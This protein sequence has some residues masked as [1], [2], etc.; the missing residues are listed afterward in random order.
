MTDFSLQNIKE[1]A[2][3][4]IWDQ[5]S[6]QEFFDRVYAVTGLPMICFD[7]SFHHIAHAFELP[8]YL[9][10][11]VE[12]S[13]NRS[14]SHEEIDRYNYLAYQEKVVSANKSI[15]VMP[16]RD[17]G[18]PCV[19]C[20]VTYQGE[21]L[22][23]CGTVLEDC[24]QNLAL[25]LNDLVSQTIPYLLVPEMLRKNRLS[26]LIVKDSLLLQEAEQINKLY[27][28]P[29]FFAVLSPMSRAASTM[30]YVRSY[31]EE[32]T[33]QVITAI[34][35]NGDVYMLFYNASTDMI[36]I[37]L[38][39]ILEQLGRKHSFKAAFSCSFFDASEVPARRRQALFTMEIGQQYH[40]AQHLYF[41]RF[42]YPTIIA[43]FSLRSIPPE[44]MLTPELERLYTSSPEK[45]PDLF[46][47]LFYYLFY[48]GNYRQAAQA[49]GIH[50]NTLLYRISQ[51]CDGSG[52]DLSSDRDRTRQLLSLHLWLLSHHLLPEEI[53][54]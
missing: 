23:Y 48:E 10:S 19:H 21:L 34:A 37:E 39:N 6:V 5:L 40:P 14:A 36:L 7:T 41:F 30:Q 22:A 11:W 4:A 50:K 38:Q 12:I 47:D 20:S 3:H 46:L 2:L 52:I 33:E 44:L 25:E 17:A 18:H 8:F 35:E 9:H 31:I 54:E 28:A 27:P 26:P 42:L 16:Q 53:H 29:Y 15:Y 43:H 32:H 1:I 13:M 24:E 45:A 51:I 49:L